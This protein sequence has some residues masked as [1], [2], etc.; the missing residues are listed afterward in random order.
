MYLCRVGPSIH[1]RQWLVS[2]IT[3]TSLDQRLV[4]ELTEQLSRL[5]Q[6]EVLNNLQHLVDGLFGLGWTLHIRIHLPE[7]IREI[8]KQTGDFGRNFAPNVSI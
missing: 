7:R 4:P 6:S 1:L 3:T 5:L 8:V 2:A